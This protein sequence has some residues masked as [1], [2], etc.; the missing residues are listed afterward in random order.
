[1]N[2]VIRCSTAAVLLGGASYRRCPASQYSPRRRSGEMDNRKNLTIT[3]IRK[4]KFA[5]QIGV[6]V[7]TDRNGA[8]ADSFFEEYSGNQSYED[9]FGDVFNGKYLIDLIKAVWGAEPSYKLLDCGSANGVT[10]T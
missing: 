2:T 8:V 7:S 6:D 5:Y 3:E 4:R 10:L 1:M 9:G